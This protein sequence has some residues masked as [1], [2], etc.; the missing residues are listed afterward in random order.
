VIT[1]ITLDVHARDV[2]QKLVDDKV[3]SPDSF[4]WQQQLRFEWVPSNFDVDI[5]ITDFK[6]KYFYEWIGNTGRLVIT[7][8]TVSD[9][10]AILQ[11]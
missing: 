6:T 2:V 1:I 5:K 10:S 8:L 11:C 4:L 7:P 9:M 3:E